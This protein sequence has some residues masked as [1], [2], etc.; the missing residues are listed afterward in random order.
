M[1][2]INLYGREVKVNPSKYLID[3]DRTVSKPQKQVKDS[4][5]Q[6]WAA[7]Y[8]CEEFCIP[9]SK[10]RIDLINFSKKVAVEVSP[11]G[12]HKYNEFFN[13]NRENYLRATKRDISKAEWC[14]KNGFRF[15]EIKDQDLKE[16]RILSKVLEQD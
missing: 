9:G 13:K 1:K 8:V 3:W 7:D 2:L 14:E 11:K 16:G 12:S 10:M 4:L 6:I 15:V 5:F